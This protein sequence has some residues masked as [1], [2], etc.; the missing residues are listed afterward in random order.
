MSQVHKPIYRG[1]YT[2][3]YQCPG[4]TSVLPRICKVANTDQYN[5]NISI[6]LEFL[7]KIPTHPNII[8]FLP[9]TKDCAYWDTKWLAHLC[10]ERMDGVLID[11]LN[12]YSKAR[13]QIPFTVIAKIARDMDNAIKHCH[14]NGVVHCDIKP[15][16]IL[17]KMIQVPATLDIAN[18][19]IAKLFADLPIP[20]FSNYQQR[21]W[22]NRELILTRGT[23]YKLA[24]FGLSYNLDKIG[25]KRSKSTIRVYRSPAELLLLA[26]NKT[27]DYWAMGCSIYEIVT[28]YT[29]FGDKQ[30]KQHISRIQQ[31]F[32][33][34]MPEIWDR[35]P[36]ISRKYRPDVEYK[37]TI[38]ANILKSQTSLSDQERVFVENLIR[39]FCLQVSQFI[40]SAEPSPLIL[41]FEQKP[42]LCHTQ[43]S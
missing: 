22:L 16:N 14:S 38:L 33:S 29:L 20:P 8:R 24:D 21:F 39:Y 6:E 36:K 42:V 28:G 9:C 17:F 7:K 15:D 3:V 31:Y 18:Q 10:I 35:V 43:T 19:R 41:Y 25:T 37:T 2:S 13:I 12:D 23:T 4:G 11:V 1:K 40:S 30:T 26:P 5:V 34:L 27:I 32:G